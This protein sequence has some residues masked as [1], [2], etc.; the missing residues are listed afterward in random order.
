MHNQIDR[1]AT[2]VDHIKSPCKYT[3]SMTRQSRRASAPLPFF[4]LRIFISKDSSRPNELQP[5]TTYTINTSEWHKSGLRMCH[6]NYSLF[7]THCIGGKRTPPIMFAHMTRLSVGYHDTP[8][9]PSLR[10]TVFHLRK[11]IEN[12]WKRFGKCLRFFKSP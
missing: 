4:S 6:G 2:V 5:N 12:S 10:R 7:V 1:M 8:R 9:T 3:R 11:G